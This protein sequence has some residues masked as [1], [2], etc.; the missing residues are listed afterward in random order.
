[1]P[2]TNDRSLFI[3]KK[4]HCKTDGHNKYKQTIASFTE[5]A[6]KLKKLY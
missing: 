6:S 1:L 3:E 4:E 2:Q 5:S